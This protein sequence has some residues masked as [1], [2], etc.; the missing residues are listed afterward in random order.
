[1]TINHYINLQVISLLRAAEVQVAVTSGFL[2]KYSTLS[3]FIFTTHE[4]NQ[5]QQHC[6][7][8][9]SWTFIYFATV[10][11]E[12]VDKLWNYR[13]ENTQTGM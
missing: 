13:T 7:N 3:N 4:P 1:M 12:I 6:Q 5:S 9:N 8:T 2:R 11:Q 10:V